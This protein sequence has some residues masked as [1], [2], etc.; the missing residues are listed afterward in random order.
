MIKQNNTYYDNETIRQASQLA[1][2]WGMPLVRHFSA[3]TSRAIE[4]AYVA[5]FAGVNIEELGAISSEELSLILLLLAD[6][7]N[8]IEKGSRIFGDANLTTESANVEA[9]IEKIRRIK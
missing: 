5:E 8:G 2:K 1:K 7:Q 3:V 4:R 6:Y 9:L